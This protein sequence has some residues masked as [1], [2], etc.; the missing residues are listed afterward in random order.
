MEVLQLKNIETGCELL[1]LFVSYLMAGFDLLCSIGTTLGCEDGRL[2]ST[3]ASMLSTPS[4][5]KTDLRDSGFTVGGS[6]N[7]R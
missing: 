4:G 1:F 5:L 6:R 3:G 7:W 2:P